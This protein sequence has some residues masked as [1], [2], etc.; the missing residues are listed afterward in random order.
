MKKQLFFGVIL[1][2]MLVLPN[3]LFAQSTEGTDFWVTLMRGDDGN[4]D[5]LLL[6]FSANHAT[7]VYIENK[8]KKYQ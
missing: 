2:A 5:A 8:E 4:Y 1:A 3:T 6:T 7:K